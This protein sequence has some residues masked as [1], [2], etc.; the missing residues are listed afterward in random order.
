M[1]GQRAM[2]LFLP[3]ICPSR[4]NQQL[5]VVKVRGSSLAALLIPNRSL[6]QSYP[7][8]PLY[9][10]T[11]QLVGT[12]PDLYQARPGVGVAR[13]CS[14]EGA[15]GMSAVGLGEIGLEV[16]LFLFLCKL[17]SDYRS[18]L[19]NSYL[20]PPDQPSSE[21]P[22][23]SGSQPPRTPSPCPPSHRPSF[24][25]RPCPHLHRLR[26]ISHQHPC[27]HLKRA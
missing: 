23:V 27:V 13:R 24:R 18:V 11:L 14:D 3:S 15:T 10:R 21:P 5:S 26:R 25:P 22:H 9:H 19:R 12:Q 8:L 17:F 2:H 20:L 7:R 16:R 6:Q 1:Y 4:P